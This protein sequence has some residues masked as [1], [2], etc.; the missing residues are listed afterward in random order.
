MKL[1]S[2]IEIRANSE[3]RMISGK[4]I[5][6]ET[7]SNDLG[8]IEIIHRGAITQDIINDSNIVFTY[9]HQ[10]DK[11]LARRKNGVGNLN[12]DLHEDGV[13][14]SF[15]APKTTLGNDLLEDV[16]CGNISQCSFAFTIADEEGAQKWSKV[17]DTYYR[18]IYKIDALYDLSAV[19][20][21][22]YEDTYIQARSLELANAKEELDT[23]IREE[24]KEEDTKSDKDEEIKD[25]V[26]EV[27]EEE[28]KEDEEK[29][30]EGQDNKEDSSDLE[31][32][33]EV[34]EEQINN[35]NEQERSLENKIENKNNTNIKMN[36]KFS[37]IKA[38]NAIAN[39]RSLDGINAEIVKAGEEEMR[40][41]GL[42]F[43]GQIQLPVGELRANVTV[44]AEGEDIVA[45]DLFDIV[46]PL[47]AKNVLVEAG[48]K[49]LSGLKGDVQLPIMSA[50]NV[51][52]AGEVAAAQDGAGAF[53]SIVLKPNRLTAYVN[54]SKQLL[55]Q[56]TLDVENIIRQDLI[57]AINS[58]L[59]STILGDGAAQDGLNPGG[60][61]YGKTPETI[62]DFAG[63]AEV[64]A[65]VE[66]N[67]VFGPCKW[68]VS[69]KFK[70]ALRALSLGEN[71]AANLFYNSEIDGTV[72]LSTSNVESKKAIYGDF[73]N[74]AIGQWGAIDVTVDP[75][76][77]AKNGMIV[78]V[79]NCYFDAKVIR[80]EAFGFAEVE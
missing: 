42:S 34:E 44:T 45:T 9:D 61:F 4:A 13:Y 38:I 54:I 10:R 1:E 6:F 16:R 58:K 31:N 72:A 30:D 69:P 35:E 56:D 76:T 43:N 2:R 66:E 50:C 40:N 14:F 29:E 62:S 12:I 70:A 24:I 26:E 74:L 28:I 71:V 53:S 75:Y 8:F 49:F 17:G 79:V 25:D 60:M 59:E 47:R 73:S 64:E 51:N 15:N 57:N 18:D 23:E 27:R 37:F 39:N 19:V 55:A 33:E 36:Q 21:P 46:S 77:Q 20:D 3:S 5:S 22:A 7:E 78:L 67:N 68:V 41:A 52:W 80:P 63:I 65:E 32:K 11:I 48:A